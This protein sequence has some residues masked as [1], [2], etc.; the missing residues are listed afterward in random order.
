MRSIVQWRAGRTNF[1]AGEQRKG[2]L[3]PE[4][5]ERVIS[6]DNAKRYHNKNRCRQFKERRR[7]GDGKKKE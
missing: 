4:M 1:G 2:K 7:A 5:E 6:L 3:L